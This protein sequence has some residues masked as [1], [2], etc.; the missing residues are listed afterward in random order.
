M[1]HNE[2]NPQTQMNF[3]DRWNNFQG[4]LSTYRRKLEAALEVHALIRDL[5]EVCD[6]ASEKVK[7][8]S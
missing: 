3:V 1:H 7:E 4:N 2:L 5:E 8:F 6:R